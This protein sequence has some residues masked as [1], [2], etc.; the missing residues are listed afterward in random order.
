MSAT[1]VTKARMSASLRFSRQVS[2]CA[3]A[4]EAS[5]SRSANMS[6]W[7][8]LILW[9]Y[10]WRYRPVILSTLSAPL[11]GYGVTDRQ[12][13]SVTFNF[14]IQLRLAAPTVQQL[15]V[16]L[17]VAQRLTVHRGNDI[18]RAQIHGVQHGVRTIIHIPTAILRRLQTVGCQ[19]GYAFTVKPC[20]GVLQVGIRRFCR[21][22]RLF[23]NQSSGIHLFLKRQ[24]FIPSSPA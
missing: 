7:R 12:Q 9:L 15:L 8:R 3:C 2:S 23:R 19:C 13:G 14:Y 17:D 6:A 24:G 10:I 18:S 16:L 21:L 5:G 11:F 4:S 20:S 1:C 22:H